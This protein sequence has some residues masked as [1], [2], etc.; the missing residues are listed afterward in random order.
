[1]SELARRIGITI[2]ALLIFRLGSYIPLPGIDAQGVRLLPVSFGRISILSLSLTSYLSAA[3]FIQLV[4]LVWRRLSALERSGE[5]GRRR[6][7]WATLALTLAIAAFQAFGVASAMQNIRGLIAD[8]GGWFLLSATASMVGGVFFLV[9]L[10]EL[11]TRHGIGNGIAVILSVAIIT[12]LPPEFVVSLELVRQG[13]ISPHDLWRDTILWLALVPA[14]VLV[15]SARRNVPVQYGA[16]QVGGRLLPPRSSVLPIKLNSAGFLVPTTVT[17][18]II[19]LP[20]AAATFGLGQTPWLAAAYEQMQFARTAHIVL[21]A[22]LVFVLAFI[23]TANVLD[24]ERAAETLQEQGGAIPGVSPG[25]ATADHLDRVVTLTTAI[26]AAWLVAISFLPE[27]L[28][29][30]GVLLPYKMG[31][32]SVLIVVCTILDIRTQA[33]DLRRAGRGGERR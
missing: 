28:V 8:P 18:W 11:I 20:L 15:E 30:A 32:G 25:E 14:I 26:G 21:G 33:R 31:G 19:F 6:I 1:M 3:I 22:V 23:Y 10:S 17:P 4:S 13:A 2:G 16:R 9:W 7:A 5:A 29:A 24:P 27:A 12:S